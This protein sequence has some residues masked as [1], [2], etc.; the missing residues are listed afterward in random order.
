[1]TELLTVA[2]EV[3]DTGRFDFLDRTVTTA[4]LHKIMGI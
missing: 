1:M 2:A 3:R 4:D